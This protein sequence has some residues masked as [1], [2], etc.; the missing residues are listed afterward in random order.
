MKRL[1]ERTMKIQNLRM[2]AEILCVIPFSTG[3]VDFGFILKMINGHFTYEL[4][5]FPISLK[6]TWFSN[7]KTTYLRGFQSSLKK[8]ERFS[9][10][11]RKHHK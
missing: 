7:A 5:Q 2:I 10:S 3:E 9:F 4:S 8:I 1:E 6:I 11:E